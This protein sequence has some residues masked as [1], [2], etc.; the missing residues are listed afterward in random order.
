MMKESKELV[1][2]NTIKNNK[3]K[4]GELKKTIFHLHTPASYDYKLLEKFSYSDYQKAKDKDIYRICINYEVFPDIFSDDINKIQ[5]NSEVFD[6]LKEFLS[7]LLI[8]KELAKNEI[9]I[10][11]IADHNT[12]K[13]VKKLIEAIKALNGNVKQ[14]VYTEVIAGIEISCADRMHVVSIFDYLHKGNVEKF[15][16]W[17]NDNLLSLEDGVIKTSYDALSELSNIGALSYIAHINSSDIFKDK[18]LSGGYRDRLLSSKFTEIIG[19]SSIEAESKVSEFLKKYRKDKI[20]YILDNDS[21]DINGLNRCYFWIKGYKVTYRMITEALIDYDVSVYFENQ[22]IVGQYISGI[23]IENKLIEGERGFLNNPNKDPFVINFSKSLNCFIGGRGTGKSSVLEIMQ[24][25]LSQRCKSAEMLEFI[26]KHGNTWLLYELDGEEYLVK[27]SM[28]RLTGLEENILSAFGQNINEKYNYNYTFNEEEVADFALKQYVDIFKVDLKNESISFKKESNKRKLL[29]K[30]FD[31]KYSVNDLVSTASGD[32]INNFIYNLMMKNQKLSSI[33]DVVTVRS[34]KGF[35]RE[36]KS[37]KDILIKRKDEVEKILN[38]FNEFQDKRLR[39]LYRQHDHFDE[40]PIKDWFLPNSKMDDYC[41]GYA[42]TKE[43]VVDY[44][45]SILDKQRLFGFFEEISK[46]TKIH[47]EF[48]IIDYND[49][50]DGK[51]REFGVNRIDANNQENL[52][53]E[54]VREVYRDAHSMSFISY[55][56][57]SLAKMETFTLE[58]NVNSKTAVEHNGCLFK[59]IKNLSLGQKVVA[60]LD[61]VLAYSDYSK[62]YRPLIIDQPED[63]LDSQYIYHNLVQ[64]LRDVKERRQVIIATHNATIV[65]NAKT[66]QII[67]METD[68]NHGVIKNY[69]YPGEDIIKKHIINYLEGGRES[70]MHKVSVYDSILNKQ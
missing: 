61:F 42:I 4:Y 24:Y 19:I 66:D 70:L 1:A 31:T 43:S 22:Q 33:Q 59:D 52:I 36:I 7:Y 28:P 11:L 48:P 10:V 35:E 9:E 67:I 44:L 12:I 64:Q 15:D 3:K 63:N 37:M 13:G 30:M 57:R 18:Y 47:V 46:P 65:T 29:E 8:A 17:L 6:S 51:I 53:N 38:I 54:I 41:F 40:P 16:K 56:K 39:I 27:M 55:L 5:Y 45:L 49:S 68:N 32:D 34:L 23:Y 2:Y 60:M 20:K 50:N 58:F 21:H 26:C 69:G 62:D 25:V 14:E